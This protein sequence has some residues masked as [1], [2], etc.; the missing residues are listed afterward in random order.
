LYYASQPKSLVESDGYREVATVNI[1]V[2]RTAGRLK[3]NY[4]E[5]CER[6]KVRAGDL[7]GGTEAQDLFSFLRCIY[8]LCLITSQLITKCVEIQPG[9]SIREYGTHCLMDMFM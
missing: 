9:G 8:D 2:S 5:V 6:E 1:S 7:Q 3:G 4:R